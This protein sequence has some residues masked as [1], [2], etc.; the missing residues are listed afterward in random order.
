MNRRG[1]W[2]FSA[3]VLVASC[4]RGEPDT[5][6]VVNIANQ[7]IELTRAIEPVTSISGFR[8][9]ESVLYDDQND[10][11]YVSNISGYGS[12]KDDTAYIV[13]IPAGNYSAAH[14]FIESGKYGVVLHAP[15]GMAIRD[16]VLWVTD[17]DVLRGFDTRTGRPVANID[18]RAQRAVM[19]NDV[20]LGPNG[21]L[22]VTDTGIAMVKAGAVYQGGD[23]IFA[24]GTD[25]S[26][27]IV[28][29][30]S[31]LRLPNG[32]KWD[33]KGNRWIV[34]SFD[35]FQGIV[36]A[37]AE[38]NGQVGPNIIARG[39]GRFDGV[40]ILDDGSIV[41]TCWSD[42]SLHWIRGDEHLRIATNLHQAADLGYDSR[43]KRLLIPSVLLGNVDVW[44]L[45][46]AAR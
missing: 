44:Q 9:P 27:R 30:G 37:L 38:V 20:A 24:I 29:A 4:Q 5:F 36:Y 35:P 7:Q 15:K 21:E 16:N 2:W 42:Y 46:E 28:A 31:H 23:K 40:E 1:R 19:L 17:I 25:N 14:I 12:A 13:R 6:T 10:V 26:V 3:I 34:V 41:V 18:L 8:Q 11:I 43:R 45:T 39:P 33:S 22:Y 32:I